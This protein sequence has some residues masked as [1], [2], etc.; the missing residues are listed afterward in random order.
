MLAAVAQ[1]VNVD[2]PVGRGSPPPSLEAYELYIAASGEFL[3]DNV[4]EAERI[5][6]KA[7]VVE[8]NYQAARVSLAWALVVNDE[9]AE[10]DS[11]LFLTERPGAQ[12]T[13]SEAALVRRMR[14]LLNGDYLKALQADEDLAAVAPSQAK[15]GQIAYFYTLVNRPRKALATLRRVDPRS[16]ELNDGWSYWSCLTDALDML[17]EHDRQ[18]VEAR[19]GRAQYPGL[20][21]TLELEALALAALGRTHEAEELAKKSIDL[22]PHGAFTPGVV[23]VDVAYELRAQGDTAAA[24]RTSTWAV[25]WYE[26]RLPDE[27]RVNRSDYARAL[28]AAER[29]RESWNVRQDIC[30]AILDPAH[31]VDGS[32]VEVD[33]VGWAGVLAARLHQRDTALAVDN[34]LANVRYRFRPQE[35]N[36]MRW[37]AQIAAVLGDRENATSLLR[38]AFAEA[39]VGFESQWRRHPDFLLLRG[40]KPY[41]DLMRPR[42]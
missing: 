11:L 16:A 2:D 22:L 17:G 6:R 28:Y 7:L 8:P 5:L 34:R 14:G 32:Q 36:A 37:R 23:A 12:L 42:G 33:C 40:Y 3:R 35:G 41:Q 31:V 30:R 39:G 1:A 27:Q 25:H 18:L 24:R 4:D 13:A 26:S 38:R 21:A 10:A 15:L 29:W 20:L 19:N 9:L